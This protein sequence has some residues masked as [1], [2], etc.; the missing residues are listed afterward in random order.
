MY[1]H[2]GLLG[3][4][5]EEVTIRYTEGGIP[6]AYFD[7]AVQVP[8]VDHKAPPDYIPIVCWREK[9]TFCAEYLRKGQQVVV[10]GKLTT[11]KWT[12]KETG[13]NRKALEVMASAIYF[14]GS[15]A[16]AGVNED[17]AGSSQAEIHC[18]AAGSGQMSDARP[19]NDRRTDR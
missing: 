8:S 19:E 13:K 2:V 6:Y 3:R 14:A 16:L 17:T 18:T 5:T 1:N 7:L 9:A 12:D 11:R 10:E 15:K 4:L